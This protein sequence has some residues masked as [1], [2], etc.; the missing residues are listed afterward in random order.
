MNCLCWNGDE[1]QLATCCW[2][3]GRV[4][5]SLTYIGLVSSYMTICS[6]D[7]SCIY[8]VVDDK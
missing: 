2:D 5:V 8:I 1:N 3:S 4:I 6:I 7:T